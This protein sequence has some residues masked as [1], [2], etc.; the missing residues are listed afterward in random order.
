MGILIAILGLA[1]LILVHEF[2][3]FLIARLFKI[4]VEEF[5][6]GLPGPK[7]VRFKRGN[8]VYGVTAIPFGGYVRLYGE[9]EDPENPAVEHDSESFI[10]K[11]WLV[12]IAVIASGAVFNIFFAVVLFSLMFMYG[13]PGYPTTTV[14]EVLKGSQ[15]EKAGIKEGDKILKIDGITTEEWDDFAKF[16]NANPG[17]EVEI[18]V[19][20]GSEEVKLKAVIGKRGGKGFLGIASKTTVKSL[21]PPQAFIE[22][23]K[24]TGSL[25]SEFI[26]L[27]YSEGKKGNLLKE[28]T[29]PVGIV[30]ET[31]RAVKIG[32]DF[33]LY[34]LG[35]ISINLGVVNLLPVP[36]LDGGRIAI[37]AIEKLVRRKIPIQVLA[38]IQLAGI[39]LFLYLM[40]Y[41]ISSDID[42]YN[43]INLR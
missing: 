1:L 22:A 14:A 37:I 30:V 4:R 16:V 36:P 7:I 11:P 2:G 21:Y 33:Y 40:V 17:K 19:Q 12:K 9:F 10:S 15:A 43:L 5:M 8:T 41:L 29:G 28:S 27:L 13:V 34:L 26:K 24:L 25:L 38:F 3:H 35:L 32:F 31:S 39:L 42:R 23:T 6:I 18:V 20:R